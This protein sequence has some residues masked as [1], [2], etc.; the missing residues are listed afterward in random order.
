M[1]GRAEVVNVEDYKLKRMNSA[2][3]ELVSVVHLNV[4]FLAMVVERRYGSQLVRLS[5]CPISTPH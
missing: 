4:E 2:R 5:F 1:V 3:D